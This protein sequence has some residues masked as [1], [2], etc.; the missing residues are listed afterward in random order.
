VTSIVK[1]TSFDASDREPSF[2]DDIK[3]LSSMPHA[4]NKPAGTRM[5]AHPRAALHGFFKA[6]D[7]C[8]PS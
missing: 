4:A 5:Q 2:D 3:P 6:I 8:Y 7:R 1:T